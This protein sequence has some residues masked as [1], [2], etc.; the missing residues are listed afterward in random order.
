VT[1]IGAAGQLQTGSTQTFAT[2]TDANL[3]L[4]IVS[5]GNT[6]TFTTLWNGLLSVVR[7][8]TG[9][10]NIAAGTLLV[11]NGTGALATTTVGGG[12]QNVGGTLGLNLSNANIWSGLQSFGNAS[13]S[14]FSAM[15]AYFGGTSTT[16]IDS[17]GNMTFGNPSEDFI[18]QNGV[19][20]ALMFATSSSNVP[21]LTISTRNSV[22]GLVGIGTTTP[23]AKFSVDSTNMTSPVMAVGSATNG[24]YLVVSNNG[25]VGIGSSTPNYMLDV[26]GDVNVASGKC[27]RVNGACIGYITK[28]AAIYATTSPGTTT[29]QFTG[30]Q[31]SAPSFAAGA[32]GTL[33][34]PQN[35]AYYA[36]EGWGGGGGGGATT[37]TTAG[38]AGKE[39][40]FSQSG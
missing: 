40:C 6:H 10:G 9:W 21:A 37:N 34:A 39:T 12:L 15:S 36:I 28:M 17:S 38:T 33:T 29:V 18:L 11:G 32:T 23:W 26:A 2:S 8:G 7:G 25:R 4:T 31:G 3:G 19:D 20:Q 5:S 30:A 13:S 35:I 1:S 14:Q 24:T 27:F 22:N 16:T